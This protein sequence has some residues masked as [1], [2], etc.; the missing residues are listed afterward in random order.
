MPAL[1]KYNNFVKDMAEGV[2]NFSTHV[3]KAILTNTAPTVATDTVRGASGASVGELSTGNGYTNGGATC[4][5]TSST[6][7]AGVYKLV[8]ADPTAWTASGGTVGPFRYI[9][10]Y[11]DTPTSPADPLIGY[12]D[13]GSAVT[14]QIGETFT[15]DL[16]QSGG[17]FTVT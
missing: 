11:N 10:L 5:F 6:Q 14:L 2:H 16:D 9:I 15:V 7:T 3:V 8:L 13:Y 17:V 1:V 4:T 12:Y